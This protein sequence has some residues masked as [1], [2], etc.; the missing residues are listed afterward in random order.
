MDPVAHLRSLIREIPDFPKPGI[1]FK[2]FTPLLREPRALALAVEL[3]ANPYRGKHVDLVIGTESRGFIFGTALAQALSAGFVPIRKPGKLP[4]KTIS[5]SYDLEYGTD[6]VEMHVDAIAPGQRVLLVDD[7]LATGGTM[8]ACCKL[9]RSLDAVVVGITVLIELTFLPGR[10]KLAP[11][12][13]VHA[14]VRY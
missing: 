7:L 6:K 2:D 5:T 3:M 1:G 11:H 10:A 4:Y 12:G 13:D 14:V 8:E 9:V